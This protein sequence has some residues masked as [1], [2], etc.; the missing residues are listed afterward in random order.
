MAKGGGI[1]SEGPWL[2]GYA[3]VGAGGFGRG[4]GEVCEEERVGREFCQMCGW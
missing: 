3:V 4:L 1:D 2:V